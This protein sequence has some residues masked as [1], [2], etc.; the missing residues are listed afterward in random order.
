MLA[1][2]RAGYAIGVV[3]NNSAD[4]VHRF[5]EVHDL[6]GIVGAVVG[7]HYRRPDLMKPNPWPLS[8]AL[9]LLGSSP[10]RAVLIGDSVTDVEACHAGGVGCIALANKPGKREAFTRAGAHVIVDD[11]AEL[12]HAIRS[13]EPYE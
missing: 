12:G 3:S 8:R 5:L 9:E 13:K 2:R 7:R 1:G 10:P 6:P 11:M 4:A